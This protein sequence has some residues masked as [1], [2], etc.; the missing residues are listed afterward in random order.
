MT[1]PAVGSAQVKVAG[2]KQAEVKSILAEMARRGGAHPFRLWQ[3]VASG[4][5]FEEAYVYPA[6]EAVPA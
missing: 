1:Y 6:M 4:T 3:E 2:T 5:Y